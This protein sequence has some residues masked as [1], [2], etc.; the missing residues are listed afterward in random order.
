M[1]GIY[2]TAMILV[3]V[4]GLNWGLVGVTELMTGTRF[5]L[6]E[7]I[8]ALVGIPVVAQIVYLVVGL[9]AILTLVMSMMK[10]CH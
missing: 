4:G 5:D 3:I 6:V 8:A 9:S 1:S 2:L 10:K 7:W